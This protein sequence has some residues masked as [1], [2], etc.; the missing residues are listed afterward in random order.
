MTRI[1]RIILVLVFIFVLSF[2]ALTVPIRAAITPS[3]STVTNSL[4][5][6]TPIHDGFEI[7]GTQV[8]VQ[9]VSSTEDLMIITSPT[10]SVTTVDINSDGANSSITVNGVTTLINATIPSSSAMRSTNNSTSRIGNSSPQTISQIISSLTNQTDYNQTAL[11]ASSFISPPSTS[12][13]SPLPASSSLSTDSMQAMNDL[14]TYISGVNYYV[15][16]GLNFVSGSGINYPHDDRAYYGISTG[17][18][19]S[20]NGNQLF[21]CQIDSATSYNDFVQDPTL[22]SWGL[23]YAIA[24]VIDAASGGALTPDV[25]DIGQLIGDAINLV[26]SSYISGTTIDEDGCAWFWIGQAFYNNLEQQNW[27]NLLTDPL[28]TVIDII[29]DFFDSNAYLRVGSVTYVNNLGVP[30]P[31]IT[32]QYF[33]NSVTSGGVYSYPSTSEAPIYNPYYI[34]GQNPDGNYA[35]INANYYE[36]FGYIITELNTPGSG[37]VYVNGYS[38]NGYAS[39]LY[40]YVSPNDQ[41]WYLLYNNYITGD[42]PYFINCGNT[43]G[44]YDLPINYVMVLGYDNGDQTSLQLDSIQL[45]CYPTITFYAYDY[46]VYGN[47]F[48]HPLWTYDNLP[49][50]VYLD[51]GV[52]PAGTTTF[53]T[54]VSDSTHYAVLNSNEMDSYIGQEAALE[55]VVNMNTGAYYS[56]T[57]TLTQQGFETGQVN[58][59]MDIYAIYVCYIDYEYYGLP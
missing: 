43:N 24:I 42:N 27:Q 40:V 59:N 7:D 11:P 5:K 30:S 34:L 26:V 23:G 51:N 36:S 20:M 6:I 12:Q 17:S 38:T 15:W 39:D 54:A 35:S 2:A 47:Y 3:N 50:P 28:G 1:K 31:T 29:L 57:S 56:L 9:N 25:A 44:V 21:H 41:N 55:E 8:T 33:A 4:P 46:Y 37:T 52:S 13:S 22:A 16:D 48:G 53:T 45:M 18:T 10:G 49:S 19:W 14:E 58:Y 32:P